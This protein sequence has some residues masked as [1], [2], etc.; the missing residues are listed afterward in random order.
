M[1]MQWLTREW[2][3]LGEGAIDDPAYDRPAQAYLAHNRRI[4][5]QLPAVLRPLVGEA[6]DLG[7]LTLH[8]GRVE[9]WGFVPPDCRLTL[10]VVCGDLQLGYRR[11]TLEYCGDVE[12]DG[13]S[14]DDIDRWLSDPATELLYDEVDRADDGRYEHRH[15]LWPKGEFGVRCRK[16]KLTSTPAESEAYDRLYDTPAQR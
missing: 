12:I 2:H 11:V 8:D 7:H 10:Q 13:A 16:L 3:A 14:V 15:L 6:D 9:Q 5:E 1:V 4:A